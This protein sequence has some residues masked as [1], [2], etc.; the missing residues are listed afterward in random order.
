MVGPN[1]ML[2]VAL[3]DAADKIEV[4]V[5]DLGRGAARRLDLLETDNNGVVPDGV[6]CFHSEGGL[7]PDV[8]ELMEMVEDWLL[9]Q[10][11]LRSEGYATAVEDVAEPAA[12]G[13]GIF[14]GPMSWL[15]ETPRED[16]RNFFGARFD[17]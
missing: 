8:E 9:D 17:T 4:L 15:E 14:W 11:T 5:V 16:P 12:K 7:L 13:V 1:T 10:P 3:Y 2:E 6:R